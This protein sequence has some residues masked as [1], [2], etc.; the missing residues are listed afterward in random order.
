M[1]VVEVVV[2]LE[3]AVVVEPAYSFDEEEHVYGGVALADKVYCLLVG[4]LDINGPKRVILGIEEC[5]ESLRSA[6]EKKGTEESESENE[7]ERVMHRS[8]TT[9][10]SFDD[11]DDD[12]EQKI[13]R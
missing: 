7:G 2:V 5:V 11:D 3:V 12:D 10:V 6:G 1:V 4:W 8:D 9:T 13:V